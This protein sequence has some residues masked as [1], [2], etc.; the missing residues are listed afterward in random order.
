MRP[1]KFTQ[2]MQEAL[3]A[4]QDVASNYNHQ[5]IGNE[6][7]LMAL[8]DQAEGV[9]R[10]LLEKLAVPPASLRTRLDEELSR[11]PKVHGGTS[12]VRIANE[13]RSTIDAAEKEMAKLKDEFLS[14]EH[15]L[16]ALS[17]S[18]A[19]A[20]KILPNFRSLP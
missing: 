18:K 11:R 12:E 9:A 13:L 7:F 16:L 6:H 2:K 20:G 10:P 14:A 5:E 3:Q 8:L 17:D 1:E 15:Y 19:P 4:A